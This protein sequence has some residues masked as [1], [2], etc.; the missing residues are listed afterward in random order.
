VRR[1][2]PRVRG[3]ARLERI[4]ILSYVG[5]ELSLTRWYKLNTEGKDKQDQTIATHVERRA[6]KPFLEKELF[7]RKPV[8]CSRT[9]NQT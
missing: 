2:R 5:L 3:D 6:G 7:K 4:G 8:L 9:T 1:G